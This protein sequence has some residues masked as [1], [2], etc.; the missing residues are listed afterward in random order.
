MRIERTAR[1]RGKRVDRSEL[2][3]RMRRDDEVAIREFYY[4]FPPALW[5]EARRGRVQPAL[6]ETS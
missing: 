2:V 1:D 3:Q 6:R 5:R 4:R